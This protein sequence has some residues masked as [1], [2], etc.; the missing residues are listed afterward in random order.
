M[1]DPSPAALSALYQQL[2]LDHYRR[3]HN[4]G[5][6]EGADVEVRLNNPTCGDEIVLRMRV[7]E[8]TIEEIRF[9]G[10]GCS[11]SQASASMMTQR[12]R[13]R[14]LADADA[15]AARF[16]EM[17]H[18]SAEAARDRALGDLRALAGVAKFPVRVRC[19]MLAWN[20]LEE[21][22]K[23]LPAPGAPS[24]PGPSGPHTSNETDRGTRE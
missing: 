20:A 18:G 22:E 8:G 17:L 21:A 12:L 3:P 14:P 4:R 24:G 6:L 2:I 1:T 9:T 7:R 16:R 13:G 23:Q 11:I 10:Q 19:A 5:E 15:L